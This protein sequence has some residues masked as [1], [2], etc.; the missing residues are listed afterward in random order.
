MITVHM[1]I[2]QSTR[3]DWEGRKGKTEAKEKQRQR[4]NHKGEF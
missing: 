1:N 2:H 4:K 3:K